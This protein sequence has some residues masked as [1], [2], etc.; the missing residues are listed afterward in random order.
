MHRCSSF[1]IR[2]SSSDHQYVRTTLTLEKD[3]AARLE[4]A[5]RRRRQSFKVI[6]NDALRAGLAALEETPPSRPFSTTGFSLGPSLV[7]SLDDVEEVLARVEGETH[8]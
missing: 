7:G 3:V 1:D 6:V 2:S 5:A 4:Q 8:R